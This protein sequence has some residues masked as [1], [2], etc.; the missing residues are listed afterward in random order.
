MSKIE[1]ASD[2]AACLEEAD[3]SHLALEADEVLFL[4]HFGC[5]VNLTDLMTGIFYIYTTE[6]L[7]G[8]I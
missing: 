5:D 1:S 2:I 7:N 3:G 6:G 4:S 8:E